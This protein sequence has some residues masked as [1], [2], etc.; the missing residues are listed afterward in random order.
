MELWIIEIGRDLKFWLV[1]FASLKKN[2]FVK[3]ASP[4]QPQV[5]FAVR[6]DVWSPLSLPAE[7]RHRRFAHVSG[8]HTIWVVGHRQAFCLNRQ[9]PAS[10]RSPSRRRLKWK[11]DSLSLLRSI[12][13]RSLS[14]HVGVGL[15]QH[16]RDFA[17]P[18]T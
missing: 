15:H 10:W 14:L 12:E 9:S 6:V 17:A 11:L 7:P 16:H 3:L 4:L 18:G 13:H 5:P 8:F 2:W 1:K